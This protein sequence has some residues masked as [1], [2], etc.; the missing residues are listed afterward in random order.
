VWHLMGPPLSQRMYPSPPEPSG[1]E[2][3]S[4]EAPGIF[5]GHK[6]VVKNTRKE[7][8]PSETFA[9]FLG[10]LRARAGTVVRT[11]VLSPFFFPGQTFSGGRRRAFSRDRHF[12]AAS[13]PFFSS[14]GWFQKKDFPLQGCFFARST[15]P[16]HFCKELIPPVAG[17]VPPF[18]ALFRS[19]S[20][21]CEDFFSYTI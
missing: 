20:D 11:V 3:R 15:R 6:M 13:V 5:D 4:R 10:F 1:E 21:K 7:A 18:A 2:L 12:P 17:D 14:R 19:T 9:V 8:R 16:R